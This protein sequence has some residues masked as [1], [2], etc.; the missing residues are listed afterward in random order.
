MVLPFHRVTAVFTCRDRQCLQ[1]R[2]TI[3]RTEH[4]AVEMSAAP[5]ALGPMQREAAQDEPSALQTYPPYARG[6]LAAPPADRT[7]ERYQLRRN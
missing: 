1:Q 3:R 2:G 5:P 6:I 7:A 4:I